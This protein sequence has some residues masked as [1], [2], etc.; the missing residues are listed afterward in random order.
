MMKYHENRFSRSRVVPWGRTDTTKPIDA[1]RNFTKAPKKRIGVFFRV[2]GWETR[3]L[4]LVDKLLLI[5]VFRFHP[6]RFGLLTQLSQQW[7][8]TCVSAWTWRTR[9]SF[10]AWMWWEQNLSLPL[11]VGRFHTVL[12]T[13]C[14]AEGLVLN[15]PTGFRVLTRPTCY[16]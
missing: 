9:L 2:W 8:S 13:A 12:Q 4:I 15:K 6:I 14:F 10:T 11:V 5:F 7:W 1:F 3:N 16:G